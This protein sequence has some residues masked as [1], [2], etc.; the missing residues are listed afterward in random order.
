MLSSG[1]TGVEVKSH[2]DLGEFV[3]QEV[4][5]KRAD[6]MATVTYEPIVRLLNAYVAGHLDLVDV[7]HRRPNSD[8][9]Y[10][11]PDYVIRLNKAN[12]GTNI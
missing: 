7:A 2:P 6:I 8:Y 11:N 12:G 9:N 3:P 5:L 10:W 4:T 1:G